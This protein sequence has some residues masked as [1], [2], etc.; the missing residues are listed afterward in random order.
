VQATRLD[1]NLQQVMFGVGWGLRRDR[2][3]S[4]DD[5]DND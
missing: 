2:N 5:N 4:D 3:G 1:D